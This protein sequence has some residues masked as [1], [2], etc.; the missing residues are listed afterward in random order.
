MEILEQQ[1]INYQVWT[2]HLIAVE[3]P[4]QL[5]MLDNL[6]NYLMEL[7]CRSFALK[8]LFFSFMVY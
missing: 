8:S 7:A 1:Y 5:I 3:L 6:Q 2:Q 4:K